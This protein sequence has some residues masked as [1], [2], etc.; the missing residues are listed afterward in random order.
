MNNIV[1]LYDDICVGL[2]KRDFPTNCEKALLKY[3][4][5]MKSYGFKLIPIECRN[6]YETK[7][8]IEVDDLFLFSHC[9]KSISK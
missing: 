4:K 3:K 7:Y 1:S 9:F 2:P 5:S 6:H 8:K